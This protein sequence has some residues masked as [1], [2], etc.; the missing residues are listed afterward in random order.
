[1]DDTNLIAK[2]VSKKRKLVKACH[3]NYFLYYDVVRKNLYALLM[4]F[5]LLPT[6]GPWMPHSALQ[7]LHVEQERH[8]GVSE[9][10]HDHHSHN[11]GLQS[12]D[13]HPIS[14][15]LVTYFNDYLHVD[16]RGADHVALKTLL[17]DK[18]LIDHV[19]IAEA[20]PT[21][22]ALSS[23][24][25]SRGPPDYNWQMPQPGIPVYL[26]TQRLRI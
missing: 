3:V 13:S 10:Q 21:I 25:P 2:N 5:L 20:V 8:H 1:M 19:F 14:F 15:D 9:Y 7:S 6:F 24:N 18:Q 11:H 17:Q 22:F 16:L 26:A 23:A 12:S 4:L